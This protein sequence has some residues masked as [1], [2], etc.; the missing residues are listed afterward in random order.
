MKY[1]TDIL[2]YYKYITL[3]YYCSKA[4]SEKSEFSSQ[5]V[6][7]FLSDNFVRAY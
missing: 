1:I 2:Q 4:H 5:L 3:F 7:V 6:V